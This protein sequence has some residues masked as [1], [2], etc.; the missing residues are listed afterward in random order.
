MNI[1]LPQTLNNLL[2]KMY[3]RDEPEKYP[4]EVWEMHEN[5]H[6]NKVSGW[7]VCVLAIKK[8]WF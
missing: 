5:L 8:S 1:F 6:F 4:Q 3:M 7:F 2:L